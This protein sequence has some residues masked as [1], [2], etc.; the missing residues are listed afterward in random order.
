[1]VSPGDVVKVLMCVDS[2][3]HFAYADALGTSWEWIE[4]TV[5]GVSAVNPDSLAVLFVID[6]DEFRLQQVFPGNHP[7]HWRS[8]VAAREATT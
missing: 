7:G 3:G 8:A 5:I 6:G 2:D 1:M 4:A